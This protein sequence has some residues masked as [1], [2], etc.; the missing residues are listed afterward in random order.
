[1]DQI[2]RKLKNDLKLTNEYLIRKDIQ[3]CQEITMKIESVIKSGNEK[4]AH[5]GG[6]FYGNFDCEEFKILKYRYR[7]DTDFNI[8]SPVSSMKIVY[9]SKTDKVDINLI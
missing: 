1:M 3:S 2:R 4:F 9:N 7:N 8:Y 5:F 6:D